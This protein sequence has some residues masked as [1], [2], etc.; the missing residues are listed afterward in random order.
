MADAKKCDRCGALYEH[1]KIYPFPQ[2]KIIDEFSA[3]NQRA[4]LE[5]QDLDLCVQCKESF[6]KWYFY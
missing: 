3:K 5:L 1:K 2:I 6:F 4:Y